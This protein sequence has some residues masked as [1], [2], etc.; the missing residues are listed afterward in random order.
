MGA[1]IVTFPRDR[2][3]ALIFFLIFFR[4]T[5]IP[6]VVLIGFWFLM[7]VLN[8]GAVADVRTGGV[9]YLAHIGGFIFG[10]ITARVFA[11]PNRA[12]FGGSRY[13]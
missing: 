2:I 3:R 1:F 9:A 11:N 4:V 7:Q 8:F 6:A 12:A 5:Y 10:A 13:A